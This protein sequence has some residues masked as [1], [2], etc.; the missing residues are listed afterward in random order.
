MGRNN[1]RRAIANEDRQ[2]KNFWIKVRFSEEFSHFLQIEP[3]SS[4]FS[5]EQR[6]KCFFILD[7]SQFPHILEKDYNPKSHFCEIVCA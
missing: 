2:V 5:Q 7:G 4:D 1:L 3:S 6:N